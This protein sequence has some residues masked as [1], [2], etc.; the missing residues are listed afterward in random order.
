MMISIIVPVYNGE[1]YLAECIDSVLGQTFADWELIIVD[2]GSTDGSG[3]IADRYCRHDDRIRVIHRVNGGM[4]VARN[5][6]IESVS[7]E[8]VYFLDCDDI[9]HPE[10][11]ALLFDAIETNK[12][13]MAIA[14]AV[15]GSSYSPKRLGK[16]CF[17]NMNPIEVVKD[18]LYQRGILHAPWGK[19]YKK[20]ILDKVRFTKGLCY[21]DLDFFYRYS[22]L[23]DK[24]AVSY[25]KLYFYRQHPS[26]I[27]HTWTGQRL[28]VLDVVDDIE[29]YMA[30]SQPELLPAARDRKLSANFNI[31]LLADKYGQPDV[32]DRCWNVIKL[33]RYGSLKDK[34]VRLKNKVGIIL[35]YLGRKAFALLGSLA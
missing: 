22:L 23:C 27:M 18:S 7:G 26:S 1:R 13:D 6:G 32:A 33:Y 21:E 9:L 10:A 12:A 14:G 24:I 20:T 16:V 8:Y 34:N 5:T 17:R 35:S 2:D 25:E 4:S 19:I 31:F 11:L 28:D 15:L 3:A 29:A 30:E